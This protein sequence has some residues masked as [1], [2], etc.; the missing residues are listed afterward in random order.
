MVYVTP[1]RS[2]V[3]LPFDPLQAMCLFPTTHRLPCK[4]FLLI[5]ALHQLFIVCPGVL[6]FIFILLG[7]WILSIGLFS[8][9]VYNL[10]LG[11]TEKFPSPML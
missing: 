1:A 4:I 10:L 5:T 3:L 2:V 9:A 11:P 6:F 7:V 8:S